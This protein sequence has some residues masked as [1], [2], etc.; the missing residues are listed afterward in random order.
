MATRRRRPSVSHEGGQTMQIDALVD[1]FEEIA[2][3]P[4]GLG[5]L[6]PPLPPKRVSPIVWALMGLVVLAMAGLGIGAGLWL[7]NRA[8]PPP[9]LPAV[10]EAAAPQAPTG[11]PAEEPDVVQL[12][13]VVLD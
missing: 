5:A 10:P 11:A 8:E 12:D 3:P 1:S 2:P 6:P 13:D 9:A 4:G 7:M